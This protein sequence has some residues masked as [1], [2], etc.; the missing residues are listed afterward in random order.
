VEKNNSSLHFLAVDM[1][2]TACQLETQAGFARREAIVMRV[3]PPSGE[4]SGRGA[5]PTGV[6]SFDVGCCSSGQGRQDIGER[7]LFHAEILAEGD[8]ESHC[9]TTE[10]SGDVE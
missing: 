4:Q 10:C 9:E 3:C 6:R 5:W 1:F 2:T 8:K 7:P